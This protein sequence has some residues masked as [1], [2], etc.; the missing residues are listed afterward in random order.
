VKHTVVRKELKPKQQYISIFAI[1]ATIIIAAAIVVYRPREPEEEKSLFDFPVGIPTS[2]GMVSAS[3]DVAGTSGEM[4][5]VKAIHVSGSGSSSERADEARVSLGVMTEDPSASEAVDDN[6]VLMNAVIQA[7]Q[8]QGIPEANIKTIQY[9]V[10]HIYDWEAKVVKGYRVSNMVEV[11]IDNLAIVGE[12]IDAAVGAGANNIQGISF[13]LSDEVAERLNTE[14][15]VKALEDAEAKATLIASTLGI[16]IT[17]VQ[18]VTEST[19]YPYV[20][21]KTFADAGAE[22]APTPI[23]EG[24]LSVSVVVKVAFTFE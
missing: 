4:S 24:S 9:S 19:Y 5:L 15:Y 7:I 8:A 14:A 3:P 23:I 10:N 22:R 6:A 2:L 21:I 17:G 13:G 20:P 12:V 16:S 1:C 18:Y 11:K